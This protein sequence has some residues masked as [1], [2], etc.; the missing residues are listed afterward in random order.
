MMKK[1]ILIILAIALFST[2]C[3]LDKT[4]DNPPKDNIIVE[5]EGNEIEE[6][7]ETVKAEPIIASGKES[8]DFTLTNLEGE[9]ISLSDFRGKIVLI[10]FW[11][12]WCTWCDVEMPDLQKLDNENDDLLVLAV[13]VNEDK[14]TVKKYMEDGE[15]SFA[16]ALDLEGKIAE[17]YLVN[18]LPNSY[19]VDEEGILIGAVPGMMTYEQMV[20]VLGNIRENN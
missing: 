20:E 12:T 17:T 11:A 15:Y 4:D 19:F 7:E 3:T 5:D 14:D 6:T 9:D 8:P 16:V 13:N 2:G 1:I 18:G 10:N